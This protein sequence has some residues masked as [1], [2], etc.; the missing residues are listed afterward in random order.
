MRDSLGRETDHRTP[1]DEGQHSKCRDPGCDCLCHDGMAQAIAQAGQY[2][3]DT[4][5]GSTTR[6]KS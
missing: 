3:Q 6:G 1:C 2:L 4:A 5:P